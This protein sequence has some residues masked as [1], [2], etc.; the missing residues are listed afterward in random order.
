MQFLLKL[1]MKGFVV[2]YDCP[3]GNHPPWA[4][5]KDFRV[6]WKEEKIKLEQ[7]IKEQHAIIVE[8]RAEIAEL[9]AIILQRDERIAELE[10]RLGL[11]S[12]NSGK[13][14]SSDGLQKPSRIQSL[15]EKSNMAQK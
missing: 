3:K 9:K 13:P 6:A 15:R 4:G 14:P 10:R 5:R 2:R 11:N 1:M 12:N 7:I 8:L